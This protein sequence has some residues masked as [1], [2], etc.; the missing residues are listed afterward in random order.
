[1]YAFPMYAQ[2]HH[3]TESLERWDQEL[4]GEG[5]AIVGRMLAAAA[6]FPT[7]K[8]RKSRASTVYFQSFTQEHN[9]ASRD[10][11]TGHG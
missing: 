1:V 3:Q 4:R 6:P 8:S 7:R 11:L 9:S 10:R 5:N 2:L